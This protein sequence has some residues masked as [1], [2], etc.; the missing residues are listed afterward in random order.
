MEQESA[1]L[2]PQAGVRAPAEAEPFPNAD[3]PTA[4]QQEAGPPVLHPLQSQ[5]TVD[6]STLQPHAASSSGGDHQGFRQ[7]LAAY[8]RPTTPTA[9]AHGNPQARNAPVHGGSSSAPEAPPAAAS[10]PAEPGVDVAALR[11]VAQLPPQAAAAFLAAA[12][13]RP[14]LPS[15]HVQSI[16]VRPL[17]SQKEAAQGASVL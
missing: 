13:K 7:A 9:A 16:Q 8:T 17:Q 3:E 1:P 12:A 15:R 5:P 4:P 6:T 11:G 2:A 10:T 14:V